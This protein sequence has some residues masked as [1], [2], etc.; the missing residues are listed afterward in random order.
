MILL[1]RFTL[2]ALLSHQ[3]STR[4]YYIG[5]GAIGGADTPRKGFNELKTALESLNPALKS[6]CE[7]I[8][9]G[10]NAP[11]VKGIKNTHILG[12]IYDDSSLA[13]A[14]NACDVFIAPSLAEN[15]S[16]VIMESLS[17]GTPVVAFDI[18]GNSD[19]IEH[20]RNGYLAKRG[21]TADLKDGIEWV[22]NLNMSAYHTLS[23]N[24]YQNVSAQFESSKIAQDYIKAYKWLMGGGHTNL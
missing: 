7:L 24:A 23:L 22:L 13:L 1:A 16:N 5:F 3:V 18:G 20:K 9:F 2:Y 19:M 11:Q 21:D 14:Y 8:V 6:Q 17:C 15:L 4:T 10:G 12:F